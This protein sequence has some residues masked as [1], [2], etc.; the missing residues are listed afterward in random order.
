MHLMMMLVGCCSFFLLSLYLCVYVF[1]FMLT[2]SKDTSQILVCM[3]TVKHKVFELVFACFFHY[4]L[5][6][7]SIFTFFDYF[8]F[9]LFFFSFHF[10][11][12]SDTFEKRQ[13]SKQREKAIVYIVYS[14][15]SVCSCVRVNKG[16]Q[17]IQL[18]R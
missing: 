1:Y 15:I 6:C 17:K 3:R 18:L 9:S 16:D 11:L 14:N 13:R 2:S 4:S 10:T 5:L 7:F 12:P 8:L